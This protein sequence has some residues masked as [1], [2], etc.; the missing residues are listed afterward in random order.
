[1]PGGCK[2]AGLLPC[3]LLICGCASYRAPA[4]EVQEVSVTD[5]TDEALA[6][7]FIMELKNSNSAAVELG[8]F[9]YTVWIDGTKV[10]AGRRSAEATLGASGSR[11]LSIPAVIPYRLM[12]WTAA[13]V[14]ARAEYSVEGRLRYV[15]P[16]QLAQILFDTGVHKPKVGFAHQGH[17]SLQ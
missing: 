10:Y 1:M 15:A 13:T 6:V 3:L 8:Q 5:A 16:D 2:P 11:R 17:V 12:G 4:I 9:T 7:A 14:P